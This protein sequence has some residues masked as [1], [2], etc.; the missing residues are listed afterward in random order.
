MVISKRVKELMGGSSWVR[1]MFETAIQ[2]KAEYGEAN[3]FDFTLGNPIEEPPP[4]FKQALKKFSSH[5]IPGMHR[6]MPN[7]GY[8]ETSEFVAQQLSKE[9]GRPPTADH[10][11]MTIG[12]AGGLNVT[13]KAILHQ[14]DEVVVPCAFL[15][16]F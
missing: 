8:P 13:L 4:G 15:H 5:P 2:L 12:A 1:K 9:T 3:I 16:E 7:S 11:V 6:Y 10:I 14:G